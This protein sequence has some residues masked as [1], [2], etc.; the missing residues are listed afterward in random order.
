VH[1]HKFEDFNIPAPIFPPPHLF[2]DRIRPYAKGKCGTIASAV[3]IILRICDIFTHK[4]G[5]A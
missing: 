5:K 3:V 4:M 1:I 2:G